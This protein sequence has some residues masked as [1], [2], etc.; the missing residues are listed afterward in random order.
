MSSPS[1]AFPRYFGERLTRI[2]SA[3][4]QREARSSEPSQIFLCAAAGSVVG[5]LVSG[6]HRGITLLHTL[7]FDLPD[8]AAL[9]TGIGV[10]V[11]R[12]LFVPLVG[13]LLIGLAAL[14]VR[15]YRSNDIVDPI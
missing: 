3:T 12:I 15:R 10:S 14:I 2:W 9:S 6:L 1:S 8:G 7:A 5:A 11:P 13:G 4:V